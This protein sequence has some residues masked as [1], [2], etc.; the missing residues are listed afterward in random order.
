LQAPEVDPQAIKLENV[1]ITSYQLGVLDNAPS[2]AP[3]ELMQSPGP[4]DAPVVGTLI[5]DAIGDMASD[6]NEESAGPEP[7]APDGL[8]AEGADADA[9][10]AQFSLVA[11]RFKNAGGNYDNSLPVPGDD[12]T[13]ASASSEAPAED[14]PT[15]EVA[16][17]Y[18][19]IALSQDEAP[20]DLAEGT[21][22][23]E[24][25]DGGILVVSAADGPMPGFEPF[26]GHEDL[27]IKGHNEEAGLEAL[28]QSPSPPIEPADDAIL[29]GFKSVSGM[30]TD[31]DVVEYREGAPPSQD[32]G[33]APIAENSPGG[34]E[35]PNLSFHVPEADSD[36]QAD[37]DTD[38]RD[39][40]L[41]R[42]H[43]GQSSDEPSG[44][45]V[46]NFEIETPADDDTL[47]SL[48][49]QTPEPGAA[50]GHVRVFDGMQMK[51][52]PDGTPGPGSQAG[53]VKVT[54]APEDDGPAV[55]FDQKAH[56]GANLTPLGSVPESLEADDLEDAELPEV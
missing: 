26:Q 13:A 41:W 21:A 2:D 11:A 30:S 6:D 50:G 34:V 18:N 48:E 14:A 20:D 42:K 16:F 15:E 25:M 44:E 12:E 47:N 31:S 54:E 37:G 7:G 49:I 1:Q 38:G 23:P 32:A 56:G 51:A 40:L 45:A 17:Y 46:A 39:F 35:Y 53:H 22:D 3:S 33:L 9:A 4:P 55:L 5:G 10:A 24:Q 19:K 29:G 52:E 8:A 28:A 43:D 36:S 27:V